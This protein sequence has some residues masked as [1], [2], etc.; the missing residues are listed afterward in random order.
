[1][2]IKMVHHHGF[3]VSD[4]DRSIRF[5]SEALGLEVVRVSERRDLPS[6]D[7]I[8]GYKNVHLRVVLLSHP[9]NDFILELFQYINP[10]AAKR[11]LSNYY[12]G[13]SHVAF[14]VDDINEQYNRLKLLGYSS[15]NPP[16]DVVRSGQTVARAM[17]ALDPDGISVEL[18]QEYADVVKE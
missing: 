4:I 18:F 12:I 11:E 16:I 8:L 1:M 5:Y 7:T 3:T 2:S 15:I 9:V 10:P 13:S 17:Y 14:Q 6:Y